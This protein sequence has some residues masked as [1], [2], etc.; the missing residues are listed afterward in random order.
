MKSTR[1]VYIILLAVSLCFALFWAGCGTDN[2][3][4]KIIIEDTTGGAAPTPPEPDTAGPPP[5]PEPGTASGP[6]TPPGPGDTTPLPAPP[7]N[8]AREMNM[9]VLEVVSLVASSSDFK[10]DEILE[11][12]PK[13]MVGNRPQ[14]ALWGVRLMIRDTIIAE[15]VIDDNSR[16][17]VM[18]ETYFDRIRDV[19]KEHDE[20]EIKKYL[21]T[22]GPPTLG[23]D[24]VLKAAMTSPLF[25]DMDTSREFWVSIVHSRF[26]KNPAW[27][28]MTGYT[29]SKT[30]THII[31]DDSGAIIELKTSQ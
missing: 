28:V 16:T 5:A 3:S 21:E 11:A 12:L 18:A 19:L 2:D 1:R 27:N 30:F 25:P 17:I 29:D 14:N 4:L 23:Y 13:M 24:G 20:T 8:D 7:T 6:S 15:Y 26:D 9:D 22:H 31:M 10:E